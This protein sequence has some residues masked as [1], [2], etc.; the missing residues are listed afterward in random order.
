[1]TVIDMSDYNARSR[2]Y[3]RTAVACGALALSWSLLSV[4]DRGAWVVAQ[5][6][7]GAVVVGLTGMFTVRIPGAKTSIAAAEIFIFLMLM[8]FGAEA[9]TIAAAVEG[10]VGAYRSSKRWTSRLG[11]PSM[12]AIS[13]LACGELL[14]RGLAEVPAG[15]HDAA[16]LVGL[17]AF[18]ALYAFVNSHLFNTLFAWKRNERLPLLASLRGSAWLMAA[19]MSSAALSALMFAS[20]RTF[21]WMVIVVGVPIIG[22][23]LSTLHFY[24]RQKSI[25]HEAAAAAEHLEEMKAS[26]SRFHS[27][28]THAAIGMAL[29]STD[30]VLT[31]VNDSLCAMLDASADALAGRDLKVLA[32]PDD[33]GQLL[34]EVHHL[35]HD[36]AAPR[37]IE[38]RL[39]RRGGQVVWCALNVSFFSDGSSGSRCLILQIQDVTAR[40]TAETQL[41]HVA[42][43][44][45]LTALP[46]RS[47]FNVHLK[48]AI[49][50][51]RAPQP[52]GFAVMYLDFDRFKVINDSL[53]HKA[54]DVFLTTVALRLKECLRSVDVIARLGGDEFAILLS[55]V[56]DQQVALDLATRMLAAIAVPVQL[57]QT[58]VTTSASIGI[59][60]STMGYDDA[61]DVLRDA[62][63]A[64]YKAKAGGK[65]QYAIFD[66]TLHELVSAQLQLESELRRAMIQDQLV[67]HYQP[68]FSL[69]SMRLRGFEALVRWNHP[70]NGM[71]D[72]AKFIPI[73][74]EA[75]LIVAL[76]EVVFEKACAQLKAWEGLMGEKG[77]AEPLTMNINVSGV[78]LAHAGFVDFISSTMDGRG[79]RPE[80]INIEVTESV[81][82]DAAGVIPIMQR[83]AGM[84]MKL[85]I[86]DFGTGYSSLS[87]LH[88]LPFDTLKIDRSFVERMADDG[89]GQEIVR[90]IIALGRA[91]GKS[92]VAEGVENET[93]LAMLR[94]LQCDEGQ[95]YFFSKPLAADAITPMLQVWR[96][97]V[98]GAPDEAPKPVRA[99]TVKRAAP[100]AVDPP[101]AAFRR[102]TTERRARR[103]A[104]EPV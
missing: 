3:W 73:A 15:I 68:L 58:E 28:F 39:L 72:P 45:E 80:Q 25:K 104:T 87:Y 48:R 102:R 52:R 9:A 42:Y 7:A 2:A 100:V 82:M 76:G 20:F 6:A 5:V 10:S 50:A 31:Q 85:S 49:D 54:G 70:E 34:S 79:I 4:L 64:M 93:Q 23:F 83:L 91:L 27:A 59:T 33:F 14:S 37:Q 29:V 61:E 98:D 67:V 18:A 12:A 78:Q 46:N 63:I 56:E 47:H 69:Q 89:K 94:E 30:G 35:V 22:M 32:H 66:T 51:A 90:S 101:P 11:T 81:L 99:C 41:H 62:D 19:H 38:L 24:F 84:G 16:Q 74:E 8:L 86:D 97:A 65:A 13:M 60:F 103:R 92:L 71:V 44:D 21:G 17:I 95:G 77:G 53:G 26:E 55:E 1:M 36:A 88:S 96:N 57:G 75:G 43:H 40:R